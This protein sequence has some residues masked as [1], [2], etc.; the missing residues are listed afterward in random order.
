VLEELRIP[1]DY[2]VGTSMGSIVGGLYASGMSAEEI[3]REMR[4]MDW[5]D[6]FQDY[7]SR[8]D[9][10][11][12]RKS[13]D[14]IYAFKAKPG[15][16]D[17]KVQLPLA[18]IRGQKF[19]LALNRLTLPVVNVKDFNRL[20]IPYRAVAAD[21]E[22]GKAVVLA[23]GSLSMSIRASMAVPAAF[24]PV[25]I[26]GRLL[27]DG[28]IAN[29][30]PVNVA[31]DMGAEVLI[32][33][34]VG[35]GLFSRKNITSALDVTGQLGNYLFTLNSEEQLK[36]LGPKDVLIRPPLGDIGGGSFERVPE[37]FPIGERSARE[38]IDA[39]RR[40]SLSPQDYARYRAQHARPRKEAPVIDS[41]RIDNHS[42]VGDA[43]IAEHISVKPGQPLDVE[44]LEQ[45]I[46][47]IYG[48]EIFESVRYE[49]V[50]EDDKNVLVINAKEKSWGPGYLQAGIAASNNFKGDST[51]KFGFLYTRTEINAL[52]GEWRL[53]GQLG[54]EPAIFADLYQPLDPQSRYFVAGKVGY[55]KLNEDEFD[56]DGNRLSRY[57]LDTTRLELAAGRNFGTWGEGRLGFYRESG[58]A[59]LTIGAPAPDKNVDLG[60][61]YLR[62]SDD[63]L[64]NVN[65]P[66]AGHFGRAEYRVSRDGFGASTDYDQGIL[67]YLH[68]FT[69]DRNTIT[70]RIFGFSTLDNTAPLGAQVRLGGFMR[71]SG[72]QENQLSGQDAGLIALS[73][74]RRINDIALL[75]T[76]LGVTYEIGNVWQD[77][78]DASFDNTIS[79][80]S[81]F[82]GVDSPIGPFYFAYGR[83]DTGDYSLYI[84]LGPRFTF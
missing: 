33:V 34:D 60:Y 78:K 63:K 25:E 44:R 66:R 61:V 54:D 46:G 6:L 9:R 70:G 49:V 75:N 11:F 1:V 58:T 55:G 59:E 17:G 56:A 3:D 12:R 81:V 50:R 68:A 76:Y 37:T 65:F 47:Q 20:P 5:D 36:T 43:V 71:L 53:G 19:D 51:F 22:T 13:D 10:S 35:S 42:R 69:W 84:Y 23:K 21:I 82:L 48:L 4:A 41:V 27:V 45:D 39:L 80:G 74:Y 7:P 77:R 24:D 28:G 38:A 29:N 30:V 18:Y 72:L 15:F 73:Y 40:Y 16:N 52:N 31:R 62:L 32:V 67:S 26:D 2:V 8:A 57:Q 83:A 64:D 79:A 14:Y